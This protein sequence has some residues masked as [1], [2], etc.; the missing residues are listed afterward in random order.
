MCRSE[1]KYRNVS[2]ISICGEIDNKTKQVNDW[3]FLTCTLQT[4]VSSF[5]QQKKGFFVSLFFLSL[6]SS[7]QQP[8]GVDWPVTDGKSDRSTT[9][10]N[11]KVFA[12]ATAPIDNAAASAM[13]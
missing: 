13:V 1:T 10:T 12:A 6:M 3:I 9:A 4:F 11:I 8:N 7:Q 2:T 5:S